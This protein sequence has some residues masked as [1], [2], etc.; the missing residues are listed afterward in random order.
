MAV[1]IRFFFQRPRL[2]RTPLITASKMIYSEKTTH[3]AAR[4]VGK[5]RSERSDP[6]ARH[7]APKAVLSI[8]NHASPAPLRQP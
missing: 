8:T 1:R 4:L 5:R 6:S 2:K 7:N 3:S